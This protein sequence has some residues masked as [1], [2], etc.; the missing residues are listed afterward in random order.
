ME[1]SGPILP[2]TIEVVIE[3]V[4]AD[5]WVWYQWQ[6]L[7]LLELVISR[8]PVHFFA[9]KISFG[10]F[11]WNVIDVIVAAGLVISLFNPQDKR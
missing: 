3:K 7:K 10:R 6:G 4:L 9:L 1:G 8:V 11:I 5:V 2:K